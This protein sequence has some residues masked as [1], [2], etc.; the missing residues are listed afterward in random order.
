MFSKSYEY[1]VYASEIKRAKVQSLSVVRGVGSVRIQEEG[2]P[3]DDLSIPRVCG[4]LEGKFN[5]LRRRLW[6]TRDFCD[7]RCC[8][9]ECEVRLR[10]SK[11]DFFGVL[12]RGH[13][14]Q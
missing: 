2:R 8:L 1:P 12:V 4:N 5:I 11:V 14:K 3:C 7:C 6:G 10:T 13:M 9:Y